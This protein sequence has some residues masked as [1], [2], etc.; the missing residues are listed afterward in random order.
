VIIEQ[1]IGYN[2]FYS[3]SHLP[4]LQTVFQNPSIYIN[5][6]GM[7]HAYKKISCHPKKKR[8][9]FFKKTHEVYFVPS[10]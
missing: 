8:S 1:Y 4:F 3:A 10:I 6:G 7:P 9:H 5:S 2:E